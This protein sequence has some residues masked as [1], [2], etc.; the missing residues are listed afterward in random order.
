MAAAARRGTWQHPPPPRGNPAGSRPATRSLREAFK[1]AALRWHPDKFCARFGPLLASPDRD[2]VL[3]RV[4][5]L[6]QQ[7]NREWQACGVVA[8]PMKHTAS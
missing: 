2:A 3:R 1:V 4:S 8:T 5:D 6:A 7:V